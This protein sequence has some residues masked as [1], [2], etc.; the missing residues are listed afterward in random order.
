MQRALLLPRLYFQHF[1]TGSFLVE[2]D[3]ELTAFLIGF[4]SQTRKDESYIHFV[5]VAPEEQHHGLGRFLYRQFFAY[6]RTH[7]RSVVRAITSAANEGSYA[8]HTR[9][10]FTPEAGP[11]E[12]DGRPVQPDYDGPGLDRVAF[13]R[14]I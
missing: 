8:F 2:R 4:L 3:G 12:V 14:S 13:V 10:G 7:G 5:G 6:S 1:T 9:M 11:G